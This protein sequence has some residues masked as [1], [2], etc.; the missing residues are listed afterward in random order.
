MIEGLESIRLEVRHLE[1]AIAFYRDGLRFSYLG[2]MDMD[3]RGAGARFRASDF[4]VALVEESAGPPR[5]LGVCLWVDVSGVDAYHDA[6]VA[7]GLEPSAPVDAQHR[8]SFT[9]ID[10]DGYR[11]CFQQSLD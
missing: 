1:Q 7:R 2:R 5:G 10:P 11:W 8:R 9:V 6:L 3:G 4:D